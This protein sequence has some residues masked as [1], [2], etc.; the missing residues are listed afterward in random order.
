MNYQPTSET[1]PLNSHREKA[2]KRVKMKKILPAVGIA[3]VVLMM[4]AAALV[5]LVS[6]GH[7]F[8]RPLS[9]TDPDLYYSHLANE[10]LNENLTSRK[11]KKPVRPGCEAT[12]ILMRHCERYFARQDREKN[13]YC[14]YLG[15][16]R[17]NYLATLF[18][19]GARWPAPSRLYAMDPIRPGSHNMK[20]WKADTLEPLA[21]KM[22]IMVKTAFTVGDERRLAKAIFNDLRK[23]NLCG[24]L[25]VV[26]WD[27]EIP[28]LAQEFGC[29]PYN[30]C[31]YQFAQSDYDSTYQIKF[32]YNSPEAGAVD[33]NKRKQY[34]DH[35]VADDDYGDADDD[36]TSDDDDTDNKHRRRLGPT[37]SFFHHRNTQV[38][39]WEVHGAVVNM[40]FDPLSFSASVGD[41]PTGG[42][43]VGGAWRMDDAL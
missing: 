23:G 32:V 5:V 3:A 17:A 6:S 33:E 21:E 1:Q 41:Y 28:S 24:K 43:S 39:A 16:E 40:N 12:V 35:D 31:P 26:S 22:K 42:K 13:E 11:T 19:D 14:G 15:L 30:G 27:H 25:I 20:F 9:E 36:N 34:D 2:R 10:A 18:G 8:R 37:R 7:T 29:G 38:E 4:V